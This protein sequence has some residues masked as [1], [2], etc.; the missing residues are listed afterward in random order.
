MGRPSRFSSEEERKQHKKEYF[1]LRY[2]NNKEEL[3]KIHTNYRETNRELIRTR[4]KERYDQNPKPKIDNTKRVQENRQ[5]YY[6]ERKK[7]YQQTLSGKFQSYKINAKRRK[8]VFELTID[9]F[10]LYWQQPCF[11]CGDDITTIGID[12]VDNTKG[13]IVENIVSCCKICN[14]M[15]YIH[16]V[17]DFTQHIRKIYNHLG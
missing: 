8:I 10:G 4:D 14:R 11:F 12:R 1:R 16:S 7:Q 5:E 9:E 3:K 15:K 2:E 13:Y 17:N 6:N